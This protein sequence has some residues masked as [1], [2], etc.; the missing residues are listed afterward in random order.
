M[1]S[2]LSIAQSYIGVREIK[3]AKHNSTIASWLAKLKLWWRDDETA[4]CGVFVSNCLLEA[5][6]KPVSEGYRARSWLSYGDVLVAPAVGAIAVIRRL[7]GG[8]HVGFVVAQDSKRGTI[9]LLG[10]NQGDAVKYSSFLKAQ[11]VG[12]RWPTGTIKP[13]FKLPNGTADLS[14]KE[15]L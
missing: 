2:W 7:D 15:L 3:G 4:W 13:V 5:G 1:P 8:Y 14:D 9:V 6:Y 11:V 12:Y 10:G